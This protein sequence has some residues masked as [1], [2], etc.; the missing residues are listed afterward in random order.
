MDHENGDEKGGTIKLERFCS[1]ANRPPLTA[2]APD[3]RRCA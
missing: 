1:A 2:V 3:G